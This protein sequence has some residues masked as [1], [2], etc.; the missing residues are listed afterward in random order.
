[1]KPLIFG[2]RP[3][4]PPPI[5]TRKTGDSVSVS[6]GESRRRPDVLEKGFLSG[7]FGMGGPCYFKTQGDTGSSDEVDSHRRELRSRDRQK[8]SRIQ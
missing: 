5:R 8:P 3:A 4:L 2:A 6:T 7:D 1:M